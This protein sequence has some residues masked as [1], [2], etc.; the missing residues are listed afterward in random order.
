MSLGSISI[1]ILWI[2]FLAV[3]FFGWRRGFFSTSAPPQPL[4]DVSIELEVVEGQGKA[5]VCKVFVRNLKMPFAPW[6]SLPIRVPH[7]DP[8]QGH[9]TVVPYVCEWHAERGP[10]Q[11]TLLAFCEASDEVDAP[12]VDQVLAFI[13]SDPAWDIR[14]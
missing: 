13:K 12:D 5:A 11:G 7:T 10:G 6:V 4:I 3:L 9:I 1:A 2:A 8:T 14:V